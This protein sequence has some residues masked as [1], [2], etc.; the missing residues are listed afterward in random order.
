[1]DDILIES[2]NVE[3]VTKVE[4]KLNKEFNMK[5]LGVGSRIL[6]IDI[7][8]DINQSRLCLSKETY[9]KKI[10]DK[11]GMLNLKHVATPTNP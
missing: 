5:D 2:K 8:R 11:F 9:L 7:W 1:M 10:F 4:A 6:G 3:D